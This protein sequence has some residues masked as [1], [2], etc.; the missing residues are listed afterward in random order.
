MEEKTNICGSE[1]FKAEECRV[2]N[3]S[4]AVWNESGVAAICR[5]LLQ[6]CTDKKELL[7]LA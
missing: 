5:R 4:T 7:I 1:N 6:R 3:A 2:V